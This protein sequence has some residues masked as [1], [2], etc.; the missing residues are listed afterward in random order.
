MHT[1]CP[2]IMFIWTYV[3]QVESKLTVLFHM[4][5]PLHVRVAI[6]VNKTMCLEHGLLCFYSSFNNVAACVEGVCHVKMHFCPLISL[7]KYT[8]SEMATSLQ[9]DGVR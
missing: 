3:Y 2:T 5:M 4:G 8:H 9:I 6:I 7:V 1:L